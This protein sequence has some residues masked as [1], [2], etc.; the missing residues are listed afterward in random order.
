MI[1]PCRLAQTMKQLQADEET[2]R[3]S[4]DFTAGLWQPW[5]EV[6]LDGSSTDETAIPQVVLLCSR[7]VIMET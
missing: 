2:G 5:Y 1:E 6:T 4:K 7:F 3:R